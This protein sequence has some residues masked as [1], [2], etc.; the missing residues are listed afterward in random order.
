MKPPE[1]SPVLNK[2]EVA[3]LLSWCPEAHRG[4]SWSELR[5]AVLLTVLLVTGMRRSEVATVVWPF[6][7]RQAAGGW[8]IRVEGKGGK[9][10][11]V[12]ISGACMRRVRV[13]WGKHPNLMPPHA[14][15]PT[16]GGWACNGDRVYDVVTRRTKELLGFRCRPHLLRHSV[17]T[18]WLRSG[19][20]IRT[21]Q[22]LL[23]HSAL[24][25]TERYLHSDSD[26]MLQALAVTEELGREPTLIPRGD[27]FA[28]IGAEEMLTSSSGVR[29][30][31]GEACAGGNVTRLRKRGSGGACGGLRGD[32]MT[33]NQYRRGRREAEK[34]LRKIGIW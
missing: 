30:M 32:G 6:S 17:A 12:P 15:V 4:C 24:S 22:L 29:W 5:D 2:S 7:F 33:V 1:F 25:S 21:V 11:I 13:L 20:D 31:T 3:E 16:E 14:A 8:W 27:L 28:G 19:V 34:R 26:R 10:R 18:L 9:A 23:G